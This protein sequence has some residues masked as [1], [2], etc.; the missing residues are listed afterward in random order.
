MSWRKVKLGEVLTQRKEFITID[1]SI[2]YKRCRVQVNRK[3]VVLRDVVK[4]IY[5]NTKKQQLCRK[6]DFIVAEIDA[7]V[8]GYGFVGENLEGAIVSSHYLLFEVDETKML[9]DYL[10]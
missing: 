3:G 9:I 4:G 6:N 5:I 7:K 1:D 8:G 2:E 10:K